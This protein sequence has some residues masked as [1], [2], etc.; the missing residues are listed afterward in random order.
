MLPSQSKVLSVKKYIYSNNEPNEL[1]HFA[2]NAIQM[3]VCNQHQK[4]THLY[5]CLCIG[6][7][8]YLFIRI[9]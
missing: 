2:Q 1:L 9:H 8:I 5:V 4:Y 7:K 6:L 3:I